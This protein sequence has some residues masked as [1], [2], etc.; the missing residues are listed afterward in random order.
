MLRWGGSRKSPH[1][2]PFPQWLSGVPFLCMLSWL[3]ITKFARW[4]IF[5]PLLHAVS[6]PLLARW[7]FCRNFLW[8]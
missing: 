1:H 6:P 2:L 5:W 3:K 4:W 7:N 8:P